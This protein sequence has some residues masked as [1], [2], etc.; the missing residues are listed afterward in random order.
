MESPQYTGRVVAALY[1]SERRMALS[2]QALIGA[3]LG[4]QLGVTDIDGGQPPS[5]RATMG[6]PPELHPG[7]R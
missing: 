6:G 2:G 5:H 7:L 1:A 3:E 4:Q